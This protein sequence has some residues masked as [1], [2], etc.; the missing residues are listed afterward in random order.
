MRSNGAQEAVRVPPTY[1]PVVHHLGGYSLQVG[2]GWVILPSAGIIHLRI[3]ATK[4]N[5]PE[6]RFLRPETA[7]P[8][9]T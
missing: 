4:R 8:R 5:L 9:Y 2:V 6:S 7:S 3:Q 1:A